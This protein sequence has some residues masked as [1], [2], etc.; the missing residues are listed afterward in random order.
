MKGYDNE[1]NGHTW[2]QSHTEVRLYVK[3]QLKQNIM[4]FGA[5]IQGYVNQKLDNSIK[6]S[7][8]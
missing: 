3:P 2:Y 1:L 6:L 4:E 8:M 7:V 5:H